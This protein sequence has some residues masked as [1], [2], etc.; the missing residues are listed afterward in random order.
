MY[1]V[2][3]P[4]APPGVSQ[5]NVAAGQGFIWENLQGG[6]K[7]IRRHFGECACGEQYSEL[8]SP[9]GA[10]SLRGGGGRGGANAPPHPPK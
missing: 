9:S 10:Q 1:N 5:T 7:H 4:E 6:Q 8:K 3:T 2:Q